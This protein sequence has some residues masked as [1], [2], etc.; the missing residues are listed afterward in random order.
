MN[1]ETI[2]LISGYLAFASGSITCLYV[3]AVG[4][5]KEEKTGNFDLMF[6]LRQNKND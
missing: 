4:C 3:V 2:N 6:T 5:I 1:I